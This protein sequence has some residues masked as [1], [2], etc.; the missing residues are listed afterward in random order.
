MLL[1]SMIMTGT[2]L[3]VGVIN[4]VTPYYSRRG[5]PFGITVPSTHQQDSFIQMLK[6]RFLIQNIVLS[7]LFSIPLFFFS[8]I[9]NIQA[10]EMWSSLYFTGAVFLFMILT[11]VLYL[12]NRKKIQIWKKEN[13]LFTDIK[14]ERIIVDTNYHSDLK[15]ISTRTIV[16]AQLLIVLITVVVTLFFYRSIPNEFPVHWNSQNV[17]DRIV[18]KTYLSVLMVPAIQLLMIPVMAFSNYSFIKSKQK[19]L[20]NYPQLTS[21][22][23]KQY[24]KAWS[25]YFLIVSVA[26][27]LLF[28]LIN[29]YALFI[30]D[31]SSF[32]WVSIVIGIFIVGIIGYSLF[33][34]WKYGQ[35]G[36]KL[37]YSQIKENSD[38]FTE[39]D[40]EKYWKWG[41]FYYNPEDPAVFVEKRFGIGST[42]NMARWQSWLAIGGLIVFCFLLAVVPF[43]ME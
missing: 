33:L 9:E 42:I 1:F 15:T 4:G 14:K 24:R 17:P 36:E 18:E 27:Q 6:K 5:T 37:V 41:V 19:L 43:L 20:S 12:S 30:A 35:G 32:E 22:Q 34:T 28:T 40:E 13:N 23:S 11:F 10:Q 26:L 38:E 29:F 7:L 39:V 3:L 21:K 8:T 31:D 25:V 2:F 16:M